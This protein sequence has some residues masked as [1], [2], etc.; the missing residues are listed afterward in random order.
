MVVVVVVCVVDVAAIL[1][2]ERERLSCGESSR[3]EER[4]VVRSGVD[5]VRRSGGKPVDSMTAQVH[6]RSASLELTAEQITNATC[7]TKVEIS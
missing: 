3:E 5:T 7:V 4:E 2:E 6:Q 1:S